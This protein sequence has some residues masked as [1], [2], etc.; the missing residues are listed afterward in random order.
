MYSCI[1]EFEFQLTFKKT[2]LRSV[3]IASHSFTRVLST[4]A[5]FKIMVRSFA[6]SV[7]VLSCSSGLWSK[8]TEVMHWTVCSGISQ[9]PRVNRFHWSYTQQRIQ[10]R[11]QTVASFCTLAKP[12]SGSTTSGW[13]Q[14]RLVL[15]F[16]GL[17]LSHSATVRWQCDIITRSFRVSSVR[18]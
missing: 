9:I 11:Q 13:L 17:Q 18:L 12:A 4:S 7:L 1:V 16:S 2:I 8:L 15:V 5:D 6:N 14:P 3:A 10:H